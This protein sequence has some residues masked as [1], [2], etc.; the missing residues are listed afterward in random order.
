MYFTQ[1]EALLC[2][3][4]MHPANPEKLYLLNNLISSDALGMKFIINTQHSRTSQAAVFSVLSCFTTIDIIHSG[5]NWHV[6]VYLVL[7]SIGCCCRCLC[8]SVCVKQ[9]KALSNLVV[10][11]LITHMSATNPVCLINHQ[12][13]VITLK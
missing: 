10:T 12:L 6:S 9:N 4:T 5:R 7:V 13:K 8:A 1:T 11:L 3:Q 2:L